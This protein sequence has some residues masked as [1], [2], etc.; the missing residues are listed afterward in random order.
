ML[1]G[2]QSLS[3]GAQSCC[4]S[5]LQEGGVGWGQALPAARGTEEG[6]ILRGWSGQA[7]V[8]G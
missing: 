2:S 8:G 7:E 4:L 3:L 1:W 6:L 5:R